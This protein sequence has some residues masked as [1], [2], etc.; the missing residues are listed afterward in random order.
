M[1]TLT[2]RPLSPELARIVSP[3]LAPA[4]VMAALSLLSLAASAVR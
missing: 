3:L 4:A 1:R 2:R